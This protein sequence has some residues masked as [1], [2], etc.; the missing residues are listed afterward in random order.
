MQDISRRKF[1]G[2][3]SCAA[4][5]SVTFLNT[6]MNLKSLNSLAISNSSVADNSGYKALVCLYQS[7]G[8][9]SFNMLI[10]RTTSRY[11]EYAATRTN[12][13]VPLADILPINYTDA[14]GYQYGLNPSMPGLQGLFNSG[15]AAFISNVGTLMDYTNKT[16][17]YNGVA[18]L[19]LGL[20]SHSD[21]TQ[22][23]QTAI[24][25]ERTA[26]GWGGKIADLIRDQN[27]NQNISMNI[28][29]AGTNIFQTGNNTV[30]YA[31]DPYYGPIGINGYDPAATWTFEQAVTNGIDGIMEQQY[32]DIF[33]KTYAET[34]INARDAYVEI[35]D[36]LNGFGGFSTAS[37]GMS[38]VELAFEQVAKTI[39]VRNTLGFQ[40]QIFFVDYGGWDHH[41]GLQDHGP[42]LGDLD[43]ALTAFNAAMEELNLADDVLTFSLSEFGRTL[44]SNGQ[45]SDHAWGGNVF[46]MGGTSLLNGNQI[47]GTY[48]TLALNSSID[49]GGGILIPDTSADTYF[50]EIARWFGVPDTDLSMLFPQLSNFYN[51]GSGTAPIGFLNL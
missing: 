1:I 24:L 14:S 5:G 4:L 51:I 49:L 37:F 6:L 30:E 31:M 8:N 13:A 35:S 42:M 40:R 28:S 43:N 7:G 29:L 38:S 44:T 12:L 21:Q 15:K 22:Q 45:G 27:A 3:A 11:N 41:E 39:A 48:P 23:W 36:A 20:F 32:T 9:D 10:P 46:V 2:Q 18:N 34:I 17:F 50:A 33:K 16:D 25:D 47:Y 26:V 19:P